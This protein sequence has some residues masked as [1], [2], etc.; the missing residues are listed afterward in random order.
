MSDPIRIVVHPPVG[1]RWIVTLHG[2]DEELGALTARWWEGTALQ[3]RARVDELVRLYARARVLGA[4]KLPA[5][6]LELKAQEYHGR[7]LT[8]GW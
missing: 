5:A 4:S 6:P 1:D 7:Q 2:S 3:A 8:F